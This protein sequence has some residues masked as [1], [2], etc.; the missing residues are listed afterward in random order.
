[1]AF[2]VIGAFYSHL[3]VGDLVSAWI[4]PILALA[5]ILGSYFLYHRTAIVKEWFLCRITQMLIYSRYRRR[6]SP[7]TKSWPRAAGKLFVKNGAL[8]YREY[9]ASDLN[10]EDVIPFPKVVKLKPGE[11]LVYASV[12]KGHG[13]P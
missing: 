3:S 13:R 1:M 10:T 6:I 11:T 8:K 2:D 4:F 9:V 7:H 12:E 5:L